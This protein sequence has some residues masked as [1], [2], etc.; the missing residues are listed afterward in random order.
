MTDVFYFIML[1]NVDFMRMRILIV[2]RMRDRSICGRCIILLLSAVFEEM[3][4]SGRAAVA[5]AVL[6]LVLSCSAQEE[7]CEL[8]FTNSRPARLRERKGGRG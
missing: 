7:R 4:A 6:G 5:V 8:Y 1:Y 3:M 2:T